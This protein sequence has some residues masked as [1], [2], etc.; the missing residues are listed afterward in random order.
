MPLILVLFDQNDFNSYKYL[1]RC[2]STQIIKNYGRFS[3]EFVTRVY[4]KIY[5]KKVRY[6]T[7]IMKEEL[8]IK[9]HVKN[10]KYFFYD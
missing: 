1:F 10:Y 5:P 6:N 7:E 2:K 4:D 8:F 9:I 3:I